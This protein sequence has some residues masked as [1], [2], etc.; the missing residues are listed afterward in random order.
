[1]GDEARL[2]IVDLRFPFEYEEGPGT[3]AAWT[4]LATARLAQDTGL[5]HWRSDL[6]LRTSIVV[7]GLLLASAALAHRPIFPGVPPTSPDKAA[8]ILRPHVSQVIYHEVAAGTE[9]VWLRF[10]AEAGQEIFLQ[11]GIPVIDRLRDYRP[12]MAVVGP[13]LPHAEVPFELPPGCGIQ[14]FATNGVR[15]PEFFAE[16]FTGTDSWILRDEVFTL[17]EAGTYYLV[18]Y[19]PGDAPGKLWLSIGEKE[20]FGLSDLGRMRGWT[21]QVRRFHEVQGTWPRLQ[22]IAA[23]GLLVVLG[24][25]VYLLTEMFD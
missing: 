4:V 11:I 20:D 3:R 25:L 10:E 2:T 8:V 19:M 5:A 24:G 16:K 1:M 12:S 6:M 9:R 14:A 7:V 23:G 15:E 17:P 13:G 21:R 18:A 22:K